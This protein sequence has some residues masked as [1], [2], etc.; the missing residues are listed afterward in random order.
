MDAIKNG[1]NDFATKSYEKISDIKD[2]V[3]NSIKNIGE[4]VTNVS[5]NIT[6]RL[7][8][9]GPKNQGNNYMNSFMNSNSIVAKFTFLIFIFL[10]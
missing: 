7:E 2:N 8:E 4:S 6:E 9:F 5:N 10:V 1:I 3:E